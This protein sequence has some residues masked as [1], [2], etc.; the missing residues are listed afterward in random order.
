MKLSTDHLFSAVADDVIAVMCDPSFH[1]TLELPDLSRPE[2]A[3]Q[4]ADGSV[5][6]LRLRYEFVGNIDSM[7]KKVIGGRTLTWVQEFRIDHAARTGTL[8]FQ[9]DADP[10]RLHGSAD[11]TF[12]ETDDARTRRRIAGELVVRV[13]LIGGTAE[14]KIVPGVIRRLD[15]EAEA[16]ERRLTTAP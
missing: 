15:V 11:I 4:G 10:K 7:A 9:A 1:T 8:T 3:E 13:P 2:V 14:R 5:T 6:W 12:E 16:L